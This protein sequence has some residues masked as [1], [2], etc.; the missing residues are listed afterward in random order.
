MFGLS[1]RVFKCDSPVLVWKY[2]W[3]SFPNTE[4]NQNKVVIRP[5]TVSLYQRVRRSEWCN[6][7]WILQERILS[8]RTIY[9]TKEKLYWACLSIS[10]EEEGSDPPEGA[11]WFSRIVKTQAFERPISPTWR[12][13][14]EDYT[15]CRLT[16]PKDRLVALAGISDRLTSRFGGSI[17][18][19]ILSDPTLYGQTCQN[20]LW[21]AKKAPLREFDS[22]HAPTWSWA[23]LD[24]PISFSLS[25]GEPMQD[26]T[27]T[28]ED[29]RS[30]AWSGCPRWQGS[31]DSQCQRTCLPGTLSLMAPTINLRRG[32]RL[33]DY[34]VEGQPDEPITNLAWL[35]RILGIPLSWDS[36]RIRRF[37]HE[38][39][40]V[41]LP[42]NLPVPTHTEA[43]CGGDLR[44]RCIVGFL[45][46]DGYDDGNN[47]MTGR[48]VVGVA[49]QHWKG[50]QFDSRSHSDG[51]KD[52]ITDIIALEKMDGVE[53]NYRR[54]GR[55]R[56]ISCCETCTWAIWG[57][58]KEL[59]T[60]I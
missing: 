14:V 59:V 31:S 12:S 22:F 23:S 21:H 28:V 13:I 60:I 1:K 49:I 58:R 20:L 37:D 17:S 39:R 42:L 41:P 26:P 32:R 57:H 30:R 4:T 5:R 27:T 47:E 18:A 43:L 2:L 38:G 24:G 29:I 48:E 51:W 52:Y 54:V 35:S 6:R 33:L 11:G 50:Q 16:Y 7:G 40:E 15:S 9:F 10:S 19:G 34:R 44:C 36:F 3:L 45:I 46:P 25:L 55:G 8:R 56:M 53:V